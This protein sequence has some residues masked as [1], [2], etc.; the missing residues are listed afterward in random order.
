MGQSEEKTL[1]GE[2][3]RGGRGVGDKKK[4]TAEH[5]VPF[6]FTHEC[7]AIAEKNTKKEINKQEHHEQL[8]IN[9]NFCR[10]V[11]SNPVRYVLHMYTTVS[12]TLQFEKYIPFVL[13]KRFI[14]FSSCNV[15]EN[16]CVYIYIYI[17]IYI[18]NYLLRTQFSIKNNSSILLSWGFNN[19][20]KNAVQGGCNF[21]V[22]G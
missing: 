17:Y 13:I 11:L 16:G 22:C 12:K 7:F 8:K 20:E 4:L 18:L 15:F 9:K 2:G 19:C 6:I 5:Y 21:S 10:Y 14:Y 3:G 1:P